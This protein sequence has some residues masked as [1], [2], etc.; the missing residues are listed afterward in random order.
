M[1]INLKIKLSA[2][3]KLRINN[4]ITEAP[5]DDKIYG[6][7]DNEWVPIDEISSVSD[8]QLT[9]N[10][11]LNLIPTLENT[12]ELSIKQYIGIKPDTIEDDTT[13]YIIDSTPE[14]FINGGTSFS[15]GYE[16][17]SDN[18]YE[19]DYIGGK[20]FTIE[21][22]PLNAKGVYNGN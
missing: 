20:T 11:G 14:L 19:T 5:S 15:D 16:D 4:Y 18:D 22:L 8:I 17:I 9:E 3:S 6:R 7:K 12:R 1:D 10:S 21:L 13:Y 2:Y